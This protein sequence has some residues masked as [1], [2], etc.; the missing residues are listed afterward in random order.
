MELAAMV[1]G[2]VLRY[3]GNEIHPIMVGG[4]HNKKAGLQTR[5]PDMFRDRII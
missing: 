4:V 5:F 1:I 2:F 3:K